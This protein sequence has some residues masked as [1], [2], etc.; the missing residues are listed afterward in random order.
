MLDSKS[1]KAEHPLVHLEFFD[2]KLTH[3]LDDLDS[4]KR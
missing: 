3:E 4:L 2:V 1:I